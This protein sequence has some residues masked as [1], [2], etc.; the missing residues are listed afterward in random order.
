MGKR[1]L[2]LVLLAVFSPL[3]ILATL[4]V[5]LL[6]RLRLGAPVLFI[7]ERPGL[8]GKTFHML[9]FRSMTDERDDQGRLK[10][11]AQR[12]PAFGKFLREASLDELPE[13]WNVLVGDMSLVG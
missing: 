2:D 8:H 4:T 6:V 10:P 12:L 13:L 1:A 7:Q 11:D 5:A 9:K 3:I